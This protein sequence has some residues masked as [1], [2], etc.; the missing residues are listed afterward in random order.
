MAEK[1]ISFKTKNGG[2]W[3]ITCRALTSQLNDLALERLAKKGIHLPDNA[4]LREK[5]AL[6]VELV[7]TVIT[8]VEFT[9]AEGNDREVTDKERIGLVAFDQ[10]AAAVIKRGIELN[11]D[12]ENE[13]ELV[14]GNSDE[15]SGS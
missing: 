7:K 6:S 10:V 8:K 3:T 15:P 11:D 2:T 12:V 13:L 5:K 4:P 9:D 14:L 1:T